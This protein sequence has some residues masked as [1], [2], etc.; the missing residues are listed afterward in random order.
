MAK[1]PLQE[2][3]GEKE[4]KWK[5]FLH[6]EGQRKGRHTCEEVREGNLRDGEPKGCI[7]VVVVRATLLRLAVNQVSHGGA[8]RSVSQSV[9]Q[10]A[11]YQPSEP[12]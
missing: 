10:S 5:G 1:T 2:R 11:N 3:D 9:S 6:E 12:K 8:L 7:I 4:G